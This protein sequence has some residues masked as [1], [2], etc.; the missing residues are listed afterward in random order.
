MALQPMSMEVLRRAI[1]SRD[2]ACASLANLAR[3]I[4]KAG[5]TVRYRVIGKGNEVQDLIGVVVDVYPDEYDVALVV[6]GTKS[7]K[8][9]KIR[10]DQVNGIIQE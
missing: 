4:F 8:Q 3:S 7:K 6:E 1:R 9:R 2:M 10:L 5:I